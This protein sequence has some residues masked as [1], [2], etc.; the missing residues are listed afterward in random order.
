[1]LWL[2]GG[3][4]EEAEMLANKGCP[5]C[6]SVPLLD[7]EGDEANGRFVLRCDN[8][9]GFAVAGP[10]KDDTVVEWDGAAVRARFDLIKESCYEI[11][12]AFGNDPDM[13]TTQMVDLAE[14]LLGEISARL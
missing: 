3:K 12:K 8:C 4:H 5:I 1:M 6:K 9:G 7:P 11:Q 2:C 13:T 14:E 10:T